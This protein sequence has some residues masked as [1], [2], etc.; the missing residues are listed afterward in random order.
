MTDIGRKNNFK[1]KKYY[2]KDNFWR[3]YCFGN[4]GGNYV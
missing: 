2:E 1:I 3:N 4:C